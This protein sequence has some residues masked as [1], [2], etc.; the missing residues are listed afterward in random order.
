[1]DVGSALSYISLEFEVVC[2]SLLL[3]QREEIVAMYQDVPF[4]LSLQAVKK[5]CQEFRQSA[6][7]LKI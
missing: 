3:C 7:L 6:D 1:M 4:F 2:V 5:E